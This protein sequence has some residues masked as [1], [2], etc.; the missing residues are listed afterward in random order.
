MFFTLSIYP[1]SLWTPD[2]N[3]LIS[4]AFLDMKHKKHLLST[5]RKAV[6][7]KAAAAQ[8]RSNDLEEGIRKVCNR[9]VFNVLSL[10]E[11]ALRSM[12]IKTALIGILQ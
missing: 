10:P 5:T 6:E 7:K 11:N 12:L 8:G 4:A 9:V 3:R 2:L 1:S